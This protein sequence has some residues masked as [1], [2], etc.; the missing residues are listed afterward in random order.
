M[1]RKYDFKLTII[2]GMM[3]A[4]LIAFGC[5]DEETPPVA[6]DDPPPQGETS[7]KHVSIDHVDGLTGQ[8]HLIVG[9]SATFHIRI[10]N[11]TDSI[12][13]GLT[14]GFRIYSPDGATWDTTMGNHTG[15]ITNELFDIGPH[16]NYASVDGSGADTVGFGGAKITSSGIPAGFN[17]I[18]L[19]IAIGPISQIS[20]GKTICIDSSFYPPGGAW[21]WSIGGS[22]YP[23]WDS[24]TCYDIVSG[25]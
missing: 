5:G 25:G 11:T 8:G 17:R 14:Q 18:V 24:P 7:D 6:S 15:A 12:I 3:L 9:N 2:I 23:D 4:S 16:I 19:E 21:L 10:N 20:F 1:T 13:K 22:F